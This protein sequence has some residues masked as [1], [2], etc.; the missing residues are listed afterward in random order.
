MAFFSVVQHHNE[1]GAKTFFDIRLQAISEDMR[2]LNF[3]LQRAPSNEIGLIRLAK[4][5]AEHPLSYEKFCNGTSIEQRGIETATLWD[6]GIVD[7]LDCADTLQFRLQG[8]KL[9]GTF[10]LCPFKK[11]FLFG[12]V[13]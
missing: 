12:R 1:K 8:Q 6:Q 10:L 11:Y 5:T 3:T 9:Q 2:Y 13:N 7:W 4:P